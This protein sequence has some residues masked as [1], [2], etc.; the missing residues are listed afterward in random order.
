MKIKLAQRVA[1]I[2]GIFCGIVALLLLLNFWHMKRHEPLES[3]TI[4]ALVNRLKQEPNSEELKQEIRSFDL[5]ARKA[6][7]TSRWQVKAGTYLLLV[8]GIV[9]AIS[10]KVYTDLRARIERPE[11]VTEELLKARANAQYWLMLTG[12]IILGLAFTAA[13]LNNDYLKD[14]QRMA[15]TDEPAT[16]QSGVEVIEVFASDQTVTGSDTVQTE[17][18]AAVSDVDGTISG[19]G[20]EAASSTQSGTAAPSGSF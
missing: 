4:E 9:L 8:G 10:L 20:I 6:Y 1:M 17:S 19:Q 11:E 7:F 2:S 13:I 16:E 5:L 12:G 18:V 14:Y 3:A 15:V